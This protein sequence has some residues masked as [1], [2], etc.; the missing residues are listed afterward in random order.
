MSPVA[1]LSAVR[2]PIG[3]FL[4]SLTSVPARDLAVVAG[5]AALSRAGV[6]AADVDEVLIGQARQ[7]GNGPNPGRQ[8]SIGLGVPETVPA[9]TI[10]QACASGLKS[11]AL[12][13]QSI[14]LGEADV[15]VA[16]GMESMTRVPHYLERG[17]LGYRLGHGSIV[18]GMYRDGFQCPLADQLMGR[19]AE[20]LAEQGDIPRRQQDELAAESQR[21]AHEAWEAG[22][23]DDEVVPVNVPSRRGDDTLFAKDEHLRPGT[24]ADS[25]A[26]LPAVFKKDGTVHAGNSSG[27]T[28][29]A[30]AVVLASADEVERR[31]VTPLGWIAGSFSIGVDPRIM[32]IGPVPATRALMER[33]DWSLGD[34][35]L[36][37]LNEAFAAQV[38]ACVRDLELDPERMNVNGGAIALGHPIGATGTRILTTLLHEMK[39]R[40]AGRGLATLC[41]SGGMGFSLAVTRERP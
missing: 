21:R 5:K 2:T 27:I 3:R 36:V 25:L 37:E 8:V 10:N 30:A 23:F 38:I 32:G 9:W 19:T 29:G 7:A 26:R 20:T 22:R 35:D 17:R 39:R 14:G 28:D 41:V 1:I 34:V 33:L 13:A 6:G 4:G 16:G 12:A 31:G 11:V 24:D 15:V 18:D 40:E